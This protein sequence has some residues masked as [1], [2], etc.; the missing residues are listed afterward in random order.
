MTTNGRI[1]LEHGPRGAEAERDRGRLGRR[2]ARLNAVGG[3]PA[4]CPEGS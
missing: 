1:A 2:T 3:T 4:G